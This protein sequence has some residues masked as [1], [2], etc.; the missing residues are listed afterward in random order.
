MSSLLRI[1]HPRF[2]ALSGAALVALLIAAPVVRGH[3]PQENDD[4]RAEARAMLNRGIEAY[5][6]AKFDD[7]VA[8]F[9][10][11]KELDPSLEIARLY[12]ATAYA[13]EYLPGVP[14][15][16]NL[17]NGELAVEEFKTVLE[18]DPS[19]LAAIDGIGSLLFNLAG[20][21]FDSEKMAESKAYHEKHIQIQPADPEPYYWVGVI[22]WS[23]AYRANADIRKEFNRTAK[24]TIRPADPLPPGLGANFAREYGATVD[25]GILHIKKAIE[26]RTDYADAMAYLNLLYRLKADMEIS[27]A[28]REDDL[29]IAEGLVDQVVAIKKA[30]AATPSSH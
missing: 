13:S 18:N 22:D 2:V 4:D 28:A 21:P 7:A 30:K 6:N 5:K 29:R 12:L 27:A 10:R 17:R 8:D 14:S 24:E 9:E 19:N 20:T 1:D 26:L 3:Q 23:I 16:E 15:K 25:E 11:A